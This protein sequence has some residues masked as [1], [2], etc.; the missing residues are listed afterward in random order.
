[1]SASTPRADN[2]VAATVWSNGVNRYTGLG[3][4]EIDRMIPPEKWLNAL[5]N[6]QSSRTAVVTA[7]EIDEAVQFRSDF[8][9]AEIN[10]LISIHSA[11]SFFHGMWDINHQNPKYGNNPNKIIDD[12]EQ[13]LDEWVPGNSDVARE[14][15][16]ECP[17]HIIPINTGDNH[18]SVIFIVLEKTK[19]ALETYQDPAVDTPSYYTQIVD[20]SIVD[21][22]VSGGI[23]DPAVDAYAETRGNFIEERL[24]AVFKFCRIGS[25]RPE[26]ELRRPIWVPRQE[27]ND[28]WSSGLRVIDFI[29]EMLRRIQDFESS[30]AQNRESLFRPMRPYFDPDYVRLDV[31]GA[32]AAM[33]L[34]RQDFRARITLAQVDMVI[35]QAGTDGLRTGDTPRRLWGPLARPQIPRDSAGISGKNKQ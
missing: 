10:K 11:S 16:Y 13:E 15:F 33:G 17:Y 27:D 7:D 34:Q 2:L 30:G 22:R 31:A 26:T 1:M 32:I 25:T 4:A 14:H 29:W 23:A 6:I 18:W 9:P 24:D 3:D 19:V 12:R 35:P 5:E 8:L 20:Y 28:N 21:P